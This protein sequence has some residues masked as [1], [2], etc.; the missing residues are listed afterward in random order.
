[1]KTNPVAS[2]KSERV[3]ASTPLGVAALSDEIAKRIKAQGLKLKPLARQISINQ[4][5]ISHI[6]K[7]RFSQISVPVVKICDYFNINPADYFTAEEVAVVQNQILNTKK[8]ARP[9]KA[10]PRVSEKLRTKLNSTALVAE[11]RRRMAEKDMTPAQ[12]TQ[13]LSVN[14]S[15][16]YNILSGRCSTAKITVVK[17]C[18]LFGINP[19][20]YLLTPHNIPPLTKEIQKRM[21]EK[22]MTQ[23]DIA[24]ALSVPP[25]AIRHILIGGCTKA[26]SAVVKICKYLGINPY[27]YLNGA[28][29]VSPLVLEMQKR[30]TAKGMTPTEAAKILSLN[31]EHFA[32]ILRG[33]CLEAR[34]A[35]RKIC[36]FL[37]ID[38]N[39][40][41]LSKNDALKIGAAIKQKL[42][43]G[44]I[45]QGQLARDISV[46][47]S[48]I[49]YFISGKFKNLKGS[50]VKV[51]EYLNID[52]NEVL[53]R[54]PAPALN[55]VQGEPKVP[56]IKIEENKTPITQM[57]A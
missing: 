34:S 9:T 42:I 50:V 10:E 38:I 25:H 28:R 33:R 32:C 55:I 12:V 56:A 44:G 8:E 14:R 40:F 5:S 35:A 29:N 6:M 2:I 31:P 54:K 22:G 3:N 53:I 13:A 41:I 23:T 37:G 30:F 47:R 36:K 16:I 39:D 57:A 48:R 24:Q 21:V 52:V 20:K 27:E 1:M 45:S 26:G 7:G 19:L 49:S 51:C 17:V 43:A 15:N 4:G 46:E 18:N 11:I